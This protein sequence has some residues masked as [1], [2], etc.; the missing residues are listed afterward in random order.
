MTGGQS[1]TAAGH[2]YND[3]TVQHGARQH[4]GDQNSENAQPATVAAAKN[5]NY[6]KSSADGQDTRQVLGNMTSEKAIE[7]FY[8]QGKKD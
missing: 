1:F 5:H 6:R 7:L 2:T 3:T 4:A 8:N